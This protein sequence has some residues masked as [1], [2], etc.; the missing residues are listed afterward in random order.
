MPATRPR[1]ATNQRFTTVATNAIDIEPAPTPTMTPQH[2]TSCHAAVMNTVSP[3]PRATITS[4]NVTT[5]R[6][7]NR[8]ISAAANG[9]IRPNSIMFTDT[10]KPIVACDQP[11]SMCSGSISTPGTDRKAADPTRV[12]KVT[13]ATTQAQCSPDACGRAAPACRGSSPSWLHRPRIGSVGDQ[14]QNR[15]YVQEFGH[16]LVR[17]ASSSSCSSR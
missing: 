3:L 10:A 9:E 1:R 12:T 17:T 13:A 8:S 15:Q 5:G 7:P 2:R 4:A 14:W 11:N 6:I 16:E